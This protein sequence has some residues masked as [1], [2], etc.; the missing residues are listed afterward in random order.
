MHTNFAE[1]LLAIAPASPAAANNIW[2]ER[3]SLLALLIGPRALRAS[4]NR[5]VRVVSSTCL[6]WKPVLSHPESSSLSRAAVRSSN[7]AVRHLGSPDRAISVTWVRTCLWLKALIVTREPGRV[8]QAS[9]AETTSN[10]ARGASAA[11]APG[12]SVNNLCSA[13][14]WSSSVSQAPQMGREPI[15]RTAPAELCCSKLSNTRPTSSST[16]TVLFRICSARATATNTAASATS[17]HHVRA[18]GP[19]AWPFATRRSSCCSK[20]EALSS[21][22]CRPASRRRAFAANMVAPTVRQSKV[23]SSAIPNSSGH[24]STES[25]N[26]IK[27][28]CAA[29]RCTGEEAGS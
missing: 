2:S 11:K 23:V 17:A 21:P 25:S 20:L 10:P 4:V 7:E 18:S 19:V 29:A 5:S 26:L 6:G 16:R 9:N 14:S 1:Q 3:A 8:A 12:Q 22:I 24:A 13:C 27:S 28:L 15:K